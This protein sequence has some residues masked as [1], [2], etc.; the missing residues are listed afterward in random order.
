MNKQ[1]KKAK[2]TAYFLLFAFFIYLVVA[3]KIYLFSGWDIVSIYSV[4]IT[5]FMLSRVIG[6]LFYESYYRDKSLEK[7]KQKGMFLFFGW[8]PFL[9]KPKKKSKWKKDYTPSVSFIIPCKD[10]GEVIYQTIKNCLTTDYP[11]NK[12]E[13]IAIN[14]GSTDKTL[15]EMK[16]A[17]KDFPDRNLTIVNFKKNQG[18]RKGMYAG[19]KLAKGEIAIQVDSDSY[20]EKDAIHKIVAPFQDKEIGATVGNTKPWNA[21]KNM[22]TKMQDA[23]YFMSFRT[24]KA[25]E[26]LFDMVFCCSGCFS[27]YRRSYIMPILKPW[28]DEKFMGKEIIFG[29]DR[30]LTNWIIRQDKK[31][32]YVDEARAYT[33]VPEKLKVFIKQQARWKKGWFINSTRIAPT[34]LKKDKFVALTYFMPLILLT[35]LTPFIAIKALIIN[36]LFFGISPLFYMSGIML[37]AVALQAQYNFYEG[38]KYGKYM[39]L[40]SILNMTILSYVLLYALYDLRNMAWGTR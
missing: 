16:R 25:T 13:V 40:W 29:D 11:E 5:T 24:L 34:I 38:G 17:A 3:L 15:S 14:D 10:E 20:P 35:L 4:A 32:V 36:P 26:S 31:T 30:A 7:N 22:L 1:K 8:I 6:S 2:R 9:N 39:L 19:F 27:A 23:Y 28:L 21:D 12:V 37:V 33:V 18:K